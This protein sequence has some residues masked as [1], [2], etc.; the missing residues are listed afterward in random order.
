LIKMGKPKIVIYG[1]GDNGK[2]LY[3]RTVRDGWLSDFHVEGFIDDN[4]E[5]DCEGAP[6]IGKGKDLPELKAKGIDNI[7]VF[8]LEN[9][10]TRLEKCLKLQ[11]MGFNFPSIGRPHNPG[12]YSLGEGVYIH[13]TATFLG[14]GQRI[15]DFS[16]IGPYVLVEGYAELG[17]GVILSPYTCIHHSSK[18]GDATLFY[19]RST[20]FANL[21]VGKDCIVRANGIVRK[22][23]KDGGK[24]RS[25]R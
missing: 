21:T 6:I 18:V 8:L 22:N 19:T 23:L 13:E 4:V 17:K 20:C 11:E 14:P 5:G 10:R 2:E 12:K 3:L 7:V 25:R 9:P 1:A 15:G 16:V 24:V